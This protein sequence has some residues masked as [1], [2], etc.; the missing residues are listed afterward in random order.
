M[1]LL[2]KQFSALSDP[3]RRAI[4]EALVKQP[5]SVGQIASEMPISRPAVSQH[6]KLLE[7]AGLVKHRSIGTRNI[8]QADPTGTTVIRDYLDKL[9][10]NALEN[11]KRVAES[12]IPQE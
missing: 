10:G 1:T 4:L 2:D 7:H 3:S 5:K 12:T 8:F 6:L 9:W 11:L